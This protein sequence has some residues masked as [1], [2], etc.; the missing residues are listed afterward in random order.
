LSSS[1]SLLQLFLGAMESSY[2][3]LIDYLSFH[4][5]L[6]LIP[7]F[8]IS[9]AMVVFIPTETIMKY[10]GPDAKSY[11]SYPFAAIAGLL[12]SVCSCTVI[13]LFVGI[14]KKGAGLGPAMT[15]LFAAPSV[16]IL[17]LIYTSTLIGFDVAFGRAIFSI[18]I[19]ILVGLSMSTIFK[20]KTDKKQPSEG[21]SFNWKDIQTKN[22]SITLLVAFFIILGLVVV[23]TS[24]TVIFFFAYFTSIVI[25]I[26]LSIYSTQRVPNLF[27]WL[28]MILFTGTSQ[29]RPVII[30]ITILVQISP[31]VANMMFKFIFVLL[32]TVVFAFFILKKFE[33]DEIIAWM[34]ETKDFMKSILP[35][36]LLGVL[37]AGALKFFIPEQFVVT[38]VGN[39]SLKSNLIMVLFGIFM[40]F[41]TLMEVPIARIF[42]DLGMA[43]GP[44]VAY[45]LAAPTISIQ[46]VLVT[47]KYLGDRKNSTYIGLVVLF[48]TFFA[49]FFG[50][51]V[52][53]GFTFI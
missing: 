19:A 52:G 6:C 2:L 31:E 42:L 44:L 39:N 15:F 35:L 40:Y 12:L 27:Y 45:L 3:A 8:F 23:L 51:L 10:L 5:L 50:L 26:I 37:I 46:S 14:Y 36:I 25:L 24:S 30:N 32:L 38:L 7:A 47:R 48:T 4:V 20:N 16:N 21:I 43:K 11:I 53:E 13:P 18:G 49:I 29:V 9:G 28:L 17:A 1:N 33:N 34:S 41:P 22:I